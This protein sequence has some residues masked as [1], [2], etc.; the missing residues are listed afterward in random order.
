MP[1]PM[2][3]Q[4]WPSHPNET[5]SVPRQDFVADALHGLAGIRF[6]ARSNPRLNTPPLADSSLFDTFDCRALS[7]F[8]ATVSKR[9]VGKSAASQIEWRITL[10]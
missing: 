3:R 10:R 2:H 8:C 5:W 9:K 7:A 1:P 6:E 4:Q